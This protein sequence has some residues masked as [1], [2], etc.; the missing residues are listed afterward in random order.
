MKG[1]QQKSAVKHRPQQWAVVWE[2]LDPFEI[3]L[4]LEFTRGEPHK[5]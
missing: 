4:H 3:P 1:S 5:G 2:F